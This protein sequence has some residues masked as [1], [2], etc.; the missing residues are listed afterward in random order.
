M[1]NQ[2]YMTRLRAQ[3]SKVVE[4]KLFR[5]IILGVIL[6]SGIIVGIET[7]PALYQKHHSLLHAIDRIILYIFAV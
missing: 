2:R 7:Y 6:S 1:E 4:S 3:T 5:H